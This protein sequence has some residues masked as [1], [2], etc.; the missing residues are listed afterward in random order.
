MNIT[1]VYVKSIRRC[2]IIIAKHKKSFE[3]VTSKFSNA[4]MLLTRSDI[5]DIRDLGYIV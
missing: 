1:I 4:F 3:V 5:I 2:G